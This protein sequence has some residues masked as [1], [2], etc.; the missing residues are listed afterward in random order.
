M[1]KCA[2]KLTSAASSYIVVM[3]RS[4][5]RA[6]RKSQFVDLVDINALQAEARNCT[7]QVRVLDAMAARSP[8][9][10]GQR[11]TEYF[12]FTRALLRYLWRGGS[13]VRELIR[14]LKHLFR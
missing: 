1:Y 8:S 2:S 11:P 6:M 13:G 4:L 3:A 10:A 5:G 9:L 7:L 12:P 14:A